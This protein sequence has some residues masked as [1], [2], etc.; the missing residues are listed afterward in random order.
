MTPLITGSTQQV[1]AV[2]TSS[3]HAT[4]SLAATSGDVGSYSRHKSHLVAGIRTRATVPTITATMMTTISKAWAHKAPAFEP[5]RSITTESTA[6]ARPPQ[7]ACLQRTFTI[8]ILPKASTNRHGL[9]RAQTLPLSAPSAKCR[10][11]AGLLLKVRP[12]EADMR[13]L[14]QS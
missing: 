4:L 1:C 3:T 6:N 13:Q 5:D 11:N 2:H 10:G 8:K 12:A 9:L 14:T 7:S